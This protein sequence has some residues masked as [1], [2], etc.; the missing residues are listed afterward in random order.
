MNF[1]I[2]LKNTSLLCLSLLLFP[3]YITQSEAETRTITYLENSDHELT[4]YFIEG[5][6]P[7]KTMMIIGG[8]QGDEPGGYL[9][10]DL[11]ADLLLKKG[12]LIVVPRA[13]F[14]TIKKNQ[15]GI[16]G[17]MNRKFGPDK[18]QQEDYDSNIVAIL[19]DLIGRSD[20]LLNLHEGSG[21]YYPE[22]VSD[23]RN[24][25]RYGQSIIA[26]AD[27]YTHSDGT[28]IELEST[29]TRVIHDINTNIYY[30]DHHFHFNNH[31]TLSDESK[32][33]E[34]RNSATFY[35]L[36]VAG[37]P[38]FGL[39]TSKSITHISTKVRYQTL[40]INA[41]MKEYDII[42][43]HPSVSLPPPELDH[44]VVNIIGN[45]LPLA[46]KNGST[47]SVPTGASIHVMSIVANYKRGLSIDIDG[48]GNTND[49]GRVTKINSPTT[50]K[51][52][53]DAFQCGEIPIEITSDSAE[54]SDNAIKISS[55]LLLS[56]L[57]INVADKNVVVSTGDTLHIIEGD[58]LRII[59]AQV[60][61]STNQEIRCNFV[62]YIGNKKFNDGDDRG[63]YINTATELMNNW[64]VNKSGKLF[65]IE[66]LH[67][68]TVIG[69]I[70]VS[71]SK[72][73]IEYLIVERDD[74]TKIALTPGEVFRCN[75]GEKFTI[76]SLVSNISS[77][78]FINTY[79][80]QGSD[81]V[82]ELILP[83][84]L[85]DTIDFELLFRRTSID[86]GTISFRTRG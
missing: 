56:G 24:P 16:N 66:A 8:I 76:V 59:R 65:R 26:D 48:I 27:I 15:R 73:T 35:A 83:T 54:I 52:Y 31:N 69:E 25:M 18:A 45:S 38:A 75:K 5:E 51:V 46:I 33:K 55:P 1:L 21:Y 80:S 44:L 60:E 10:A 77:K 49:L 79:I 86:I 37:I 19:K 85:E 61:D 53:K 22:Y 62:G 50:I 72:P 82:K 40:A 70:Y 4:I 36:T 23:L 74:G 32:H 30:T 28:V 9:A 68:R 20:V 13:N 14:Y 7:G 58:V 29:A 78:P 41:F 12:N 67:D 11:Y 63:Y 42:P 6:K 57:E 71:L 81:T 47:L 39:E 2:I 64:S 84:V 17:D 34:Q 43:E 3:L